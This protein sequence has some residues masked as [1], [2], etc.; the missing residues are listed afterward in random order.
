MWRTYTVRSM[1]MLMV[2]TS[3]LLQRTCNVR[4]KE[5]S[6]RR[7]CKSNRTCII[8]LQV[9]WVNHNAENVFRSHKEPVVIVVH[10]QQLPCVLTGSVR[11]SKIVRYRKLFIFYNIAMPFN[12][13]KYICFVQHLHKYFSS[14]LFFTFVKFSQFFFLLEYIGKKFK[15][16]SHV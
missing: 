2:C 3:D 14:I 12:I 16:M 15:S 7:P 9:P 1:Y 8:I 6:L 5:I 13:Q 4:D 10:I 11:S